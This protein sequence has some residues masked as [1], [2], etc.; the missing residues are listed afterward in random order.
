ME[1]TVSAATPHSP[2]FITASSFLT[3]KRST[4]ELADSPTSIDSS[5]SGTRTSGSNPAATS[6]ENLCG[7]P[8]ARINRSFIP[9]N[10]QPPETRAS[11]SI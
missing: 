6:R 3:A 5:T 4:K 1:T 8:E 11:A 10:F 7:D 2:T 9:L